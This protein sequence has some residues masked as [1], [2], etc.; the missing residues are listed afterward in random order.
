MEKAKHKSAGKEA[1]SLDQLDSPLRVCVD[2]RLSG[3]GALGGVEQFVIGLAGGLS[4]LS[5]ES[6]EYSF[7]TYADHDEWLRPYVGGACRIVH[8]F[9]AT[10][11]L[12]W[13]RVLRN[14]P[15][16]RGAAYKFL[17]PI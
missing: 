4:Q 6:I 9:G 2:A 15:L 16:L 5:E 1:G 7:L 17:N 12:R 14:A 10:R 13:S 11:G 3:G 8:G